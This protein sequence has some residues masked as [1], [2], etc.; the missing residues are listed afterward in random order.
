MPAFLA[1]TPYL[2]I[3]RESERVCMGK[4]GIF[5]ASRLE[6]TIK[7]AVES[8]LGPGCANEK[9]LEYE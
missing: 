8:K 5:K 2:L 3:K 7:D 6:Q 1:R 4:D 9:M